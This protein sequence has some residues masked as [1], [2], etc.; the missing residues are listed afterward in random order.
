M[1]LPA[2]GALSFSAINVELL[3]TSTQLL[4][5]DDPN[6]RVV[7][8]ITTPQSVISLSDFYGKS[9]PHATVEWFTA[10]AGNSF[11]VPYGV[12]TVLISGAGGGG[13]AAG[14]H[15]GGYCQNSAPGGAGGMVYQV[16]VA[17]SPGDVITA[18]V[19]G[20]GTGYWYAGSHYLFPGPG[21]DTT[22]W[23]NGVQVFVC[24][25]GGAAA[26]YGVLGTPSSATINTANPKV[27]GGTVYV[28]SVGWVTSG[29]D[30]TP[31]NGGYDPLGYAI[32]TG[33]Y[34]PLG[35]FAQTISATYPH[36]GK[37]RL[38]GIVQISY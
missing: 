29:C 38:P 35:V 7:A 8:G 26:Y 4:S 18:T 16:S 11:T 5:I 1:A 21:G 37:A 24:Y 3:N 2:S 13:G 12:K 25:G 6:T 23:I 28:A 9:R 34:S 15:I 14:W 17:V 33:D 10:G 32:N 30:W 27:S 20:T 22:V 19:G 36:A 31:N